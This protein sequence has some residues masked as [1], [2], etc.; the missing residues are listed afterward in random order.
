MPDGEERDEFAHARR[1]FE[2]YQIDFRI[3]DWHS[4]YTVGQRLAPSFDYKTSI[5]ILPLLAKV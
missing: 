4:V 3:C 1:I 5:F 2:P